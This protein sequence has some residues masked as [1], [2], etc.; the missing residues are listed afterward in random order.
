MILVDTGFFLA[1]L[2]A[3]DELNVRV[4]SVIGNRGWPRAFD[5]QKPTMSRSVTCSWLFDRGAVAAISRGSK[6]P[7]TDAP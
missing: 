2:D 5:K 7:R 1:L 4:A 6:T 3:H